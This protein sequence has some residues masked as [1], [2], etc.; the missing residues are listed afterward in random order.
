MNT[1]TKRSAALFALVLGAGAQAGC[2][3]GGCV[4][5]FA[6]KQAM[7][8]VLEGEIVRLRLECDDDEV[9]PGSSRVDLVTTTEPP[10]ASIRIREKAADAEDLG[11]LLLAHR[12]G[13]T[14]VTALRGGHTLASMSIEVAAQA[15]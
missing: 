5:K 9:L 6:E 2:S 13:T 14:T 12:P 3:D 15:H 1:T 4:L 11:Y 8:V 7:S 10:I